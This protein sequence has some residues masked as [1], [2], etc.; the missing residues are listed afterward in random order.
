MTRSARVDASELNP[1][2]TESRKAEPADASRATHAITGLEDAAI[3]EA[4]LAAA[5]ASRR[6]HDERKNEARVVGSRSSIGPRISFF[7]FEDTT[8]TLDEWLAQPHVK[9]ELRKSEL[10]LSEV[11]NGTGSIEDVNMYYA[12]VAVDFGLIDRFAEAGGQ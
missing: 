7:V 5:E 4:A 1:G 8:F 12:L 9:R 2:A 3:S 10:A 11:E 6:A